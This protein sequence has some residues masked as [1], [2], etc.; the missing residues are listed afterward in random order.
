MH[1]PFSL[2]DRIYNITNANINSVLILRYYISFLKKLRFLLTIVFR[3][4]II[5]FRRKKSIDL[6]HLDY[7]TE[8]IFDNS[9]IILKYR[10]R[11]ALWYRLGNHKT[12]EKQ[13]KIFNLKK[14]DKEFDFVVY[15][16]FQKKKYHLIFEPKLTIDTKSFKTRFHNLSNHLEFQAAPLLSIPI[17]YPDIKELQVTIPKTEITI[18]PIQTITNAYNQTDFI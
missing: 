9:Y 2:A 16:F 8:H 14:I 1:D 15:G 10:F 5:L 13:I 17:F 7:A 11:N 6:L 4:F 12:L 3:F 18:K